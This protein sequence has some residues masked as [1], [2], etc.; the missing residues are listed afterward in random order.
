MEGPRGAGK[1]DE[2]ERLRELGAVEYLLDTMERNDAGGHLVR[3]V[4]LDGRVDPAL[5]ERAFRGLLAR[6][7]LFRTR[8]DRSGTGRPV[9]VADDAVRPEL[10]VV[11]RDGPD[12]WIRVFEEQLNAPIS[13]D[14]DAPVRVRLLASERDGA[15]IIVTAAHSACDGRTLFA[16]CRDLIDEYDA[17][18][19]GDDPSGAPAGV[20]SPPMEAL[21]PDWLTGERLDSMIEAFITQAAATAGAPIVLFP[22]AESDEA[23]ISTSHVSS[24]RLPGPETA[25]LRRR[26]KANGTSV[27]GAIMAAEIQALAALGSPSPEEAIVSCVTVDVRPQLREPVPLENLGAYLGSIFTRHA[28]VEHMPTWEVAREVTSQ[29]ATKL[30]RGDHLVMTV[31]GERF[32]DEF[33]SVDRPVGS[34]S[35]ANLGP[36]ELTGGT[37][38]LRPRCIR[39]GAPLHMSKYPG[40]YCQAVTTAGVLWLTLIHVAPRMA[41]EVAHGYGEAVVDRLRHLACGPA[42]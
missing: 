24:Y 14:G 16:F 26:A 20:V 37:S 17:L 40:P 12:H 23:A 2:M 21:L 7:P 30:D 13:V 36:Q 6:R 18:A 5:L 33:V 25:E 8:I 39:G 22:Y 3:V 1:G 27:T 9:F 15:E 32:V 41:H 42:A 11:D 29:L 34:V 38:A 4:E 31:L 19:R 10:T 28:A 35:L